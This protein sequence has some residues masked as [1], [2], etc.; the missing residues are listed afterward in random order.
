MKVAMMTNK[1]FEA[2]A[3]VIGPG[4]GRARE[5]LRSCYVDGASQIQAAKSAG[6]SQATVSEYRTKWNEKLAR[7]AAID[8]KSL[9]H[10]VTQ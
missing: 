3:A 2:I 6:V 5:A 1:D 8:W 10:S 9:R 4:E 7:L